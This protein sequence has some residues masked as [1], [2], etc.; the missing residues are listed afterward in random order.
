M[1]RLDLLEVPGDHYSLLQKPNV[2]VLAALL[3]EQL[4]GFGGGADGKEGC[5]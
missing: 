4:G 2:S 1:R 5:K 3:R